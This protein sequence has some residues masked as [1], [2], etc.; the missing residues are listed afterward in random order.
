[1]AKAH[2]AA[3]GKEASFG[4]VAREIGDDMGA[5][6]VAVVDTAVVG[7]ASSGRVVVAVRRFTWLYPI[8]GTTLTM[9]TDT[10]WTPP[11]IPAWTC[12]QVSDGA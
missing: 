8:G 12:G 4:V 9:Y 6:V 3:N 10:G 2:P 7:S 5:A 1:M 11:T